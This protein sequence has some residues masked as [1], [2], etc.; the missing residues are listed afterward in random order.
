MF[1]LITP[2]HP[3]IQIPQVD[4]THYVIDMPLSCDQ[5]C[6]S[7]LTPSVPPTHGFAIY[8][9]ISPFSNWQYLGD[10]TLGCPSVFFRSPWVSG[11]T[12][13]LD[14]VNFSVIEPKGIQIGLSMESIEFLQNLKQDQVKLPERSKGGDAV[15]IA[16]N[17]INYIGSIDNPPPGFIK[18]VEAWLTKFNYKLRFDPTFYLKKS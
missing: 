16:E 12:D 1:G 9:A 15:A 11:T 7:M 14:N 8:W 5:F 3:L 10:I 4:A 18:V 17:L 6:I 2:C 13:I